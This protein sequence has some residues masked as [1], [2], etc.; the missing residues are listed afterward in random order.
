MAWSA[1]AA[2]SENRVIGVANRLPWH[3]PEDL[4]F[5]R[6][7]TRG[8]VVVMG[9]KTYESIGKPL[10]QRENIVISRQSLSLPGC[11]VLPSLEALASYGT[12]KT[13][14][15]IGGAQIYAQALPRVGDLYLTWVKRV[16][17]DGDAFFPP[18]EEDF[19]LVETLL[20]TPEMA[21]RHYQNRRLAQSLVD[22]RPQ[23]V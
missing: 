13:I 16:I 12:P 9:R 10:P 18:F 1:I 7:R 5:F 19:V 14:W 3:L 23:A 11:T 4:K 20:E 15:I 17:P 6:E 21:I 2:L 22:R 8:Q